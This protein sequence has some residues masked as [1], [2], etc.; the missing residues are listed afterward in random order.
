MLPAEFRTV[1]RALVLDRLLG[2]AAEL[3]AEIGARLAAVGHV[4]RLAEL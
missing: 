4:P 3:P 2:S 1:A